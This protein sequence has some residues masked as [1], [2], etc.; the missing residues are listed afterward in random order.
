M[1]YLTHGLGRRFGRLVAG[2]GSLLLAGCGGGGDFLQS[3]PGTSVESSGIS[4]GM[5]S[6][7]GSVR[8]NGR[9]LDTD[10]ATFTV[11]GV[12]AT[13]ADLE[14]GQLV[15]VVVDFRDDTASSVTY[16]DTIRGPVQSINR[17]SGTLNV[18]GQVV[19]IDARTSLAGITLDALVVNDIVTV[20]G[21]RNSGDSILASLV[22]VSSST[23][24]YRV[25]G[26]V[27]ASGSD[28][29]RISGL[30]VDSALA[31]VTGLT[32]GSVSDGQIAANYDVGTST[33]V[34]S[35]LLDGFELAAAE[36]DQ[37]EFE[38]LITTFIS[39]TDFV[40]ADQQVDSDPAT[41]YEFED[42]ST[43]TGN[44]LGL[45]VG[46]EVEGTLDEDG[47]LLAT[48]VIIKSRNEVWVRG[49]VTNID[50]GDELVGLLGVSFEFTSLTRF[51]DQSGAGLKPFELADIDLGDALEVR[52][53]VSGNRVVASFVTRLDATN[54]AFVRARVEAIDGNS[55][56]LTLLDTELATNLATDFE[57]ENGNAVTRS[58]FF[59]SLLEVDDLVRGEWDSFSSVNSPLDRLVIE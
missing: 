40:I 21:L 23:D 47:D 43:A 5:V 57:D 27:S 13:Q 56:E 35:A 50:S 14:A 49:S 55:F 45:N 15:R 17:A 36:D 28:S 10:G 4:M 2:L 20:S 9:E 16:V 18:L 58:E 53:F 31:N 59:D 26:P 22:R 12:A 48:R 1:I 29:F 39:T 38:A 54:D 19:V 52:A 8:L 11:N 51:D 25:V 30:L 42:G 6:G 7:F 37:V 46:V 44:D 24:E 41:T 33:L 3:F 34:A 32:S